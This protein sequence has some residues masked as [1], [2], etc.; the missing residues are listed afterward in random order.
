MT[1]FKLKK[2]FLNTTVENHSDIHEVEN[3]IAQTVSLQKGLFMLTH[4][5]LDQ[6]SFRIGH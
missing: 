4:C 3:E 6:I 5:F 1:E 2:T